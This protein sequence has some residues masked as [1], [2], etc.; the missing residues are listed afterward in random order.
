MLTKRQQQVLA[1]ITA[2]IERHD[3]APSLE[4]VKAHL[5]LSSVSTVSPAS[6]ARRPPLLP[7]DERSRAC[8]SVSVAP[9]NSLRVAWST[10][11]GLGILEHSHTLRRDV[12]QAQFHRAQGV[13]TF[14]KSVDASAGTSWT[15]LGGGGGRRSR[16]WRSGGM[17][18]TLGGSGNRGLFCQ[19]PWCSNTVHSGMMIERQLDLPSLC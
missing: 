4:E 12:G 8:S 10:T 2:F 6:T 16:D 19:S 13:R 3:Y 1:F 14:E 11:T 9:S 5:G 7:P 15:H 17:P 18:M